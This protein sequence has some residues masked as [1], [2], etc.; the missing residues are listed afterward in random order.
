MRETFETPGHVVLDLRVPEG[1]LDVET[2][3]GQSTT[4]ELTGPDEDELRE[5]ARIRCRERDGVYEVRVEVE[6][7]HSFGFHLGPR[8]SYVLEV[9]VPDGADL[10]VSTGTGDL[11]A[12]GD[13][14]DVE[15]QTGSGDV[16]V[17]R[18]AG[19]LSVKSGSGDVRV[20]NVD[21]SLDVTS[22]S[23]DV[24]VDRVASDARIRSASGDVH[25]REA[26]LELTV[27]TASGDQQID[28]V[29]AGRVTLQSASGDM[30]VGIRRGSAL[31]VD[32]K[33]MSGDTTSEF[34]LDDAPVEETDG[35]L[36]EL[37]ATAMSGDITV[38]RA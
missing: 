17:E 4:V 12:R 38:G 5:R 14:S 13:Y 21:G 15:V 34:A 16:A 7:R 25:V 32:A 10:R 33:S 31:W 26:G 22:A 9:E 28:T 24:D 8:R 19:N 11:R 2:T 29:T 3:P 35:P 27:Q 20:D 37:R 30:H 23:G 1:R 18:V 6:D 36:V